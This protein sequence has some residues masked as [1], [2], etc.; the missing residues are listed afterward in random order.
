ML[1]PRIE[2]VYHQP[3]LCLNWPS[4]GG[5][6]PLT[7]RDI[8]MRS[9]FRAGEEG[10]SADCEERDEKSVWGRRDEQEGV[11]GWRCHL[12]AWSPRLSAGEGGKVGT[13][14]QSLNRTVPMCRAPNLQAVRGLVGETDTNRQSHRQGM[15]YHFFF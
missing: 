1:D 10:R 14:Q 2:Q 5:H 9:S 3:N 12:G 11:P 13:R 6:F 7:Q 4:Q 8:Q 15:N